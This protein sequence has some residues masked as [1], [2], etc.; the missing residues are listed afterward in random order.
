MADTTNQ[1]NELISLSQ[2]RPYIKLLIK[3]W[4]LILL[5]AGTGYASGRL[6]T[7]RQLNI[8]SASAEVLLDAGKELDYQKKMMGTMGGNSWGNFGNSEAKD[9]QRILS[10]F[11]LIGRA[12][13]QLDLDID[14]YFV[15]RLRTSQVSGYSNLSIQADPELF[16][17]SFLGQDIDLFIED[18]RHYLLRYIL[19]DG[20]LIEELYAFGVPI[21]GPNLALTIDFVDNNVFNYTSTNKQSINSEALEEAR[22]QHFRFRVFDRAQRIG[23]MRNS[24]VVDNV[25][26][27]NVLTLQ[28]TSTLPGRGQKFLNVL[29]EIYINYTKEARLESSLKTELFINRQLEELVNIMDSLELQVDGFKAQNDI[30]DLTRE[31][32]DYFNSLVQLESSEGELDLRLEAMKSLQSY[33]KSGSEDSGLPPTSYL[34]GED[35]LLIEQ[36]NQLFQ[37]RTERTAALLDV[38]EDSF[39]IRRLDS[40]ISNARFTIAKYINDT[41]DALF[42]QRDNL[43]GQITNLEQRLSGIPATQ[44]DIISM[45][46]KLQVN[47]KLYVFLL[48]SRAQNVISRAGIAPQAIIIE[49]ARL[50]GIIGPDKRGTIR[51]N[52]LL[53][54][55]VALA[56]AFIR[57]MLFE[58]LESTQELREASNI[59]V[60]AGLPHYPD[61]EKNPITI[62]A[63]SRSQI[64]EAFRSLRTNLQYLLS[65]EGANSIL[66]S[67]LHPG[68]GKSFVATNLATVL[69]KTGKKVALVDFDMHKPKVHKNFKLSNQLGLSSF[70]IG[71]CSVSEMQQLGPVDSLHIY[72][73]GPVP[74]NASELV[75]NDRLDVLLQ[76]L[77]STYDYVILDT[78]PILLITDALVLM[79]KV[80]T[81]LLVTN[82]LK[83]TKR[84]IK[85]LE[86]ALNQNNLNHASLVLNN[87]RTT[88]WGQYYAKYAYK[89]GYGYGYGYGGAKYGDEPEAQV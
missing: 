1:N 84:G 21:E 74:P 20:E 66:I 55:I 56:F 72:T 28:F 17:S 30:L 2:L 57:M 81:G 68:E 43:R 65:K 78:P 34:F 37:M 53:G 33:L 15:G 89:Y 18:E 6:I 39:S 44:R 54:A 52:T 63:D 5:L 80:D 79:S 83:S 36:V 60:V 85:H 82:T 24:L 59:S 8:Y 7:H 29:S 77:K 26:G 10:S 13:D 41:E 49:Q 70:L 67:S 16:N 42:N 9:Q 64:T 87:I 73:A 3:N 45:E 38:T 40:A 88:R 50:G 58:R 69:A 12:V 71:R 22:R 46:R 31:Q 62:L 35:Q 61:W 25:K 51:N 23:Q 86:E 75:L 47:E 11:D 19:P 4:W 76:E 32:T 14:Y 48:E 27:T